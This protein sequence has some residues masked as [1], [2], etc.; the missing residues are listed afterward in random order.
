[1]KKIKLLIALSFLT[2]L[3]ANILPV[4]ASSGEVYAGN[5]TSSSVYTLSDTV[6]DE[7]T[8]KVAYQK[9]TYS[10]NT[11]AT[12][13]CSQLDAAGDSVEVSNDAQYVFFPARYVNLTEST[14]VSFKYKNSGVKR[15][16]LHAEYYAGVSQGGV[17]YSPGYKFVCVNAISSED[18]WNV[19]PS[20]S[21]DGYDVTTIL[22]GNYAKTIYDFTLTGFRLYFDYGVNVTEER[23]F[24]VFGYEV[25]EEN[26]I[27]TFT[28]DPKPT[29]ISKLTSNDVTIKN[30]TFTVDSNAIVSAKIYDYTS[31][32]YKLKIN[33]T[34]TEKTHIDFRLDDITVLSKQYGKGEHT[35]YLEL[36]EDSYSSVEME[37]T[38]SKETTIKV[39]AIEFLAPATVDVFSGSG[40]NVTKDGD[41][42]VVNY[43]YKSGYNKLSAAIRNY[44]DDYQYLRL[45]FSLSHP[46]IVGVYIDDVSVRSHW[47]YKDPLAVGEHELLIDISSVD[48]DSSSSVVIYLDPPVE[49]DSGIAAEKTVVFTEVTLLNA[50]DLPKA[51]INVLDEFEYNYDGKTHDVT[52]VTT[53]SLLPLVYEYKLEEESDEAYTTD[54][55]VDAGVYTVRITSPFNITSDRIFGKTYAYSK[56]II[57]KVSVDTPSL[58]AITI[59]YANNKLVY[60]SKEVLVSL[61]QNYTNVIASGSYVTYGMTLYFKY[62]ESNNYYESGTAVVT[63]NNK[64]NAF[65]VT[66]DYLDESTLENIPATVEYSTDGLNW[67]SGENKPVKLN[68]KMIYVFRTKATD[69][70]FASDK[71]YLAIPARPTTDINVE[72][73]DTDYDSITLKENPNLEYRLENTEW[74]DTG[75]FSGFAF[76]EIVYIYVRVKSTETSFAS[77]EICISVKVGYV[78]SLTKV[79]KASSKETVVNTPSVTSSEDNVIEVL[80]ENTYVVT[81]YS[82]FN[83]ALKKTSNK[84]VTKIIVRGTINLDYDITIEGKVII[85]GEDGAEIKFENATSKRTLYNAKNS[86]IRFENIKFTRTVIDTTEGYLFRFNDNGSIWFVNVEFNVVV[87]TGGAD[88]NIDRITY[89]P[90]GPEVFIYFDNCEFNTEGYFYRGTLIFLNSN[91]AEL[92]ATGGSPTVVDLRAFKIDYETKTFTIPAKC[93]VSLDSEFTDLLYNGDS[94]DSNTKYYITNGSVTFTYTTKDLKLATP[95]L[96]SVNMDYANEVITFESNYLVSK[97]ADFTDLLSSGATIAPGMKLYIKEIATGIYMDSDVFEVTLPNRPE[98]VE[99]KCEFVCSFGFA[100]EYYPNAEYMINNEYQLAPIFIGLEANKTYVVTVRIAATDNS[101]ASTTYQV[102]VTLTN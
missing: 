40:F 45:K 93:K 73:Y 61:D 60:D 44:N 3:L 49:A 65:N 101:F 76:K 46:I 34:L 87:T 64:E 41:N 30:N 96:N 51:E 68:P 59:D 20:K 52:G 55:P 8:N 98:V 7:E 82:E 42:I 97:N 90:S 71:V 63:L 85:V 5:A 48:I 67:I 54:K 22:F 1:M 29:R 9:V 100:M 91:I 75:Y 25:H 53:D 14:V 26:Q 86:E 10:K 28:T 43:S 13:T 38:T 31:E 92:P 56:I 19:T 89:V 58:D 47:T 78:N 39:K 17:D 83:Q 77:E 79:T 70:S 94:F 37:F 36:T 88:L 74:Q 69:S 35:V 23:S 95:T 99:L 24:E 72:L 81:N 102:T 11:Y 62:I 50:D 2:L 33:F 84:F 18:A 21:V 4:K 27:P 57:N 16:Y 6:Y 66:I 32:N 15:I 80:P 12:T